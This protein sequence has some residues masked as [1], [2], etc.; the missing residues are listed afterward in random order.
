MEDVEA[1]SGAPP[2]LFLNGKLSPLCF[3]RFLLLKQKI[4]RPATLNWEFQKCCYREWAAPVDTARL[5]CLS[6]PASLVECN[7][8]GAVRFIGKQICRD[9]I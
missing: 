8:K 9:E 2:R 1:L 3:A 6:T 4:S 5:L 7:W